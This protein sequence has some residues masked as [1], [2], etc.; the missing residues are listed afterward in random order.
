MVDYQLTLQTELL[1]WD[2]Q[3]LLDEFSTQMKHM[4]C[5]SNGQNRITHLSDLAIIILTLPY[6][7]ANAERSFFI[8]RKIESDSRGNHSKKTVTALLNCKFNI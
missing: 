6:S 5:P 3:S 2:D 1:S 4:N 7:N 8:L